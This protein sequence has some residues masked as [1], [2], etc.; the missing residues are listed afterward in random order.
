MAAE[1]A[2]G[3][4]GRGLAA[5]FV[6]AALG[7][8]ALAIGGD[9]LTLAGEGEGRTRL[10]IQVRGAEPVESPSYQVVLET[11]LSQLRADPGVASARRGEVSRD[12]LATSL[13]VELSGGASERDDTVARLESGLDSGPLELT[14]AG[15]AGDLH[16]AREGTLDDLRLLALALPVVLLLAA[17]IG[18]PA[19]L[20]AVLAAAAAIGVATALVVLVA[21]LLDSPAMALTGIAPVGLLLSLELFLL[22]RTGAPRRAI[23]GAALAATVACLAILA[24]RVGYLTSIGIGAALASLLAAP[25]A[26]V[27][28]ST[29]APCR[30]ATRRGGVLRGLAA[31]IRWS[32]PAA[33][34][35]AVMAALAMLLVA[36]P[37]TRLEANVLT[38]AATP[39]ISALEL[40]A[41]AA[42]AL[43]GGGL[44]IAALSRT[45][46]LALSL[47]LPAALPAAAAGGFL[48]VLF[49]DGRL[50][51]LLD[52]TGTGGVSL[53]ALT[54]ATVA[55]VAIG[56]A[57]AAALLV[58]MRE[59]RRAGHRDAAL[60]SISV[61]GAAAALTSAVGAALALTLLGSGLV[62]VKQ[63]GVAMALGLVVDLVAVRALIAPAVLQ[64]AG[65]GV[66]EAGAE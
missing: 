25:A 39:P 53:G 43:V 31:A 56:L 45:P 21:P 5:L 34:A 30:P 23:S 55:L 51:E 12:R 60:E 50:E 11:M 49:Q 37:A 18:P 13:E 17:F 26:I 54:A 9:R 64:L 40:G 36:V 66:P 16:E 10:Q 19:F 3:R 47:T 22:L 57:R 52:Y 8:I 58:P 14:F 41:A 1:Q 59:G 6:V 7:A 35:I 62:F 32:R 29:L 15:Q 61:A 42:I 24:L 2:E 65:P 48:V 44:T 4:A 38:S 20:R 33:A 46:A 28:A 63:F 27:A